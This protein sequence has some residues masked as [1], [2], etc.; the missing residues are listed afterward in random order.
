MFTKKR[1]LVGVFAGVFAV[2]S[3]AQVD[4][5]LANDF[6][7]TNG[8][9]N[10]N[11]TYLD[12]SSL[13]SVQTPLNNGNPIYPAV[14]GGYWG[15]G[16]DLNTNTPDLF[17]AQV[18]GSNAGETNGDFL[19][20]DIVS[21]SPN[22]GS[23]LFLNWTA[24]TAGTITNLTLDVWYAHSL[25]SRITDFSLTDNSTVLFSGA[26]SPTVNFNRSHPGSYTYVAGFS[27]QA[28]D[29]ISLGL[30]KAAGQQYGSLSGEYLD[31]TYT[32]Q[33]VPEPIS[34]TLLGLGAVAL[35]RK[36]RS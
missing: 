16:N 14:S 15:L 8:D 4:V 17:K 34:M 35:L 30:T 20:G 23:T 24:P 36:K 6:S 3:Y 21:H 22:D 10:G 26:V 33:A 28:G 27:V 2:S 7:I 12:N 18:D 19:K 32:A 13:L 1:V 9:P 25:V 31:F 29:V 11:W 5:N